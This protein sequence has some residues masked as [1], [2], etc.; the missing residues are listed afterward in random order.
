MGW[1]SLSIDFSSDYFCIWQL[2]LMLHLRR[3]NTHT[4]QHA[5]NHTHYVDAGSVKATTAQLH[6]S[7]AV[8]PCTRQ[9]DP[10]SVIH[11]NHL[12]ITLRIVVDM[13]V[14]TSVSK[15]CTRPNLRQKEVK[16]HFADSTAAAKETTDQSLLTQPINATSF[17]S[18]DGT[19][20]TS[21]CTRQQPETN[22]NKVHWTVS[23]ILLKPHN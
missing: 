19:V 22:S 1:D 5:V 10:P 8:L 21:L 11:K 3:H 12:D 2:S 14:C 7:S 6:P 23:S 9:W 4:Q 20:R 16:S 18:W 15:S 13:H 17:N